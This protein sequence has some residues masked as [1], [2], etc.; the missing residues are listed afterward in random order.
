MKGKERKERKGKERRGE[1]MKYIIGEKLPTGGQKQNS[2]EKRL[3]MQ[4]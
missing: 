1:E 4:E 2:I 3:G